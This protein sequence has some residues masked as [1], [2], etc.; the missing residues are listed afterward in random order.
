MGVEDYNKKAWDSLV[1]NGNEWTIPVD[2]SVI[3]AARDGDLRIV[4]TPKKHIPSAW[5]PDLSGSDTLCLASGGG[6]Q[7][8]VLAAAGAVV[9]VF[10]NSPKQLAQDAMVGEREGLEIKTVEGDMRDLSCFD[11]DSFDLI[12]HP[13]SNGFVSNVLPVWREAFRVLA[14]GWCDACGFC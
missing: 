12:V 10:D 2:E 13:C 5:Y 6:Q 4:L 9:T 14:F 1:E 11:D 8:P 3:A 7:G